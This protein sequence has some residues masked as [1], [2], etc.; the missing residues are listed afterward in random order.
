MLTLTRLLVVGLTLTHPLTETKRHYS[1]YRTIARELDLQRLRTTNETA[2][3]EPAAGRSHVRLALDEAVYAQLG[4]H[5]ARVRSVILS[6]LCRWRLTCRA[7]KAGQRFP[8]KATTQDT[9]VPTRLQ[10]L[11]EQLSDEAE[12]TRTK[13]QAAT[14]AFAALAAPA[15][16]KYASAG[17]SY[18]A[19][20]TLAIIALVFGLISLRLCR[21]RASFPTVLSVDASQNAT[22]TAAHTTAALTTAAAPTPAS[23][24]AAD[25]ATSANANAAATM[26]AVPATD[27]LMVSDVEMSAEKAAEKSAEKSAERAVAKRSRRRRKVL[28]SSANEADEAVHASLACVRRENVC[29]NASE[30]TCE[31]AGDSP[32]KKASIECSGPLSGPLSPGWH[33]L[34]RRRSSKP[35]H[36]ANLDTDLD[37][38]GLTI[39]SATGRLPPRHDAPLISH[40][41]RQGSSV[42]IAA[43]TPLGLARSLSEQ[44]AIDEW[45]RKE[46]EEVDG[47]AQAQAEPQPQAEPQAAEEP[48]CHMHAAATALD[49]ALQ[50]CTHMRANACMYIC[51]RWQYVPLS[52]PLHRP[53]S[54]V[55]PIL[56]AHQLPPHTLTYPPSLSAL[57]GIPTWPPHHHQCHRQCHRPQLGP[58]ARPCEFSQWPAGGRVSD[59]RGT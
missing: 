14:A 43:A 13:P 29:E 50:V 58:L 39:G 17:P 34:G 25:A 27:E 54:S 47:L 42:A 19:H 24:A 9:A 3:M 4:R 5:V 37:T 41:T 20:L 52:R 7:S 1:L 33:T 32:G 15:R 31:N 36:D 48:W 45:R 12:V 18:S 30:N 57:A 38:E 51:A 35:V 40:L 53:P 16:V 23:N 46:E 49:R 26:A 22:P 56:F 8:T 28:S 44:K 10:I 6:P 11:E 55:L 2:T 59:G 21:M